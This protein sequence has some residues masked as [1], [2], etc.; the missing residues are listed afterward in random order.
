VGRVGTV[1]HSSALVLLVGLLGHYSNQDLQGSLARLARKLAA[2]QANGEPQRQLATCRQRPRRPGW[3]LKA[4]VRVL[5]DR[6]E[7][8]RAKDIHA[9]V[10]AALGEPVAASSVK[11]ALIANASGSSRRLVRV[12]PG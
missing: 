12:A 5:A 2:V 8:M 6:G 3:V 10:E 1:R 7:P 11:T 9:A 4:I